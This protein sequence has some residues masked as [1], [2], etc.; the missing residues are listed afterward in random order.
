MFRACDTPHITLLFL[1]A[2][3]PF[4]PIINCTLAFLFLWYITVSIH[5]VGLL[6]LILL[7]LY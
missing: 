7:L 1:A 6:L 3:I 2:V 5:I 4:G